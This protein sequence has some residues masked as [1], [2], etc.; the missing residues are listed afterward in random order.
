[1][2]GSR[3]RV[4]TRAS[5][6][7]RWQAEWVAGELRRRVGVD[8]ELV[9]IASQ[10]DQDQVRPIGALGTQGVFTKALQEALLG[11]TI[12]LA[13]HSLK[14]LPTEPIGGLVLAAVPARESVADVLLALG[15]RT[16]AELPP[17]A[18]VGTGSLRRRAQL[19]RAR[20][21]LEVRDIRGNVDTRLR[22]LTS[23]E[24]AALVLARAGLTRLERLELVS[25]ELPCRIMLPAVGQGALG[26][27]TRA[28]DVATRHVL[29]VL[30]DASAHAA[31]KAER[32]MLAT[33]RGGCLAPVAGWARSD[34]GGQMRLTGRVLSPDGQRMIES[35]AV[36]AAADP[37]GL[38]QRVA[39]HLLAQ[40][41]A[42][43]IAASRPVD[44]GH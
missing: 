31:V 35:D 12:D 8:V 26:L 17:G 6:L 33:L 3:L 4:G 32:R 37:E 10:G 29:A 36:G 14:D 21:D 22:K 41:A 19:L 44:P 42:E 30:D 20:A 15:E 39:E 18:V 1:M 34:E 28:D 11:G 38:G 2:S 24:Y 27:E 9:P 5:A 40:G 13:V 7:A 43:L 23:G 16:L 25:E